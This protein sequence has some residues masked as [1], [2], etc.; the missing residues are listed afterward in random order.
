MSS[1]AVIPFEQLRMTDVERGRRQERV[2]RRNDQPA[3]RAP[4]FACP[5]A[6]PPRLFAFREFLA[7]SGLAE[8]IADAA[9]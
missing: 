3:R 1:T 5:A 7:Q 2:A 4:A 9:G 8:R 6:L